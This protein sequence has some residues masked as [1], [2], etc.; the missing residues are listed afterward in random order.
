[1]GDA[2]HLVQW[3]RLKKLSIPFRQKTPVKSGENCSRR[4]HLNIT[5]LYTFIAQGQGQKSHKILI[6]T[7][8]LSSFIIHYKFQPLVFNTL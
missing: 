7:K 4:S 8:R 5:I 1:M 3:N 6:V 2:G